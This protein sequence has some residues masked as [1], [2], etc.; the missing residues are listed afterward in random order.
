MASLPNIPSGRPKRFP[1]EIPLQV[2]IAGTEHWWNAT[3]EDISANGVRF[4][5]SNYVP[6]EAPVE[7]RFRLPAA[8]TGDSAV[9][10]ECSG[11]VVRTSEGS[12]V[13]DEARVAVAFSE[14]HLANPDPRSGVPEAENRTAMQEIAGTIH[15][16]NTLL[17]VVMGS[18]ELLIADQSLNA[19][20]REIATRALRAVEEASENVRS[21]ATTV[22][23]LA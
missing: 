2:R 3:T 6:P 12:L 15:R 17:F 11:R 13:S 5:T 8:L 9:R 22:K 19:Q 21:L 14:F 7:V 23:K 18:A 20:V 1:L 10:V 16:L 4:R